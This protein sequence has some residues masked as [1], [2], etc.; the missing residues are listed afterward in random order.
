M[1]KHL[2]GTACCVLAVLFTFA[3]FMGTVSARQND[4][5][6]TSVQQTADYLYGLLEGNVTASDGSSILDL[7]RAGKDASALASE[8]ASTDWS[9]LTFVQK[10]LNAIA[11]KMAGGSAD[12]PAFSAE[13]DLSGENPYNLCTLLRY[14]TDDDAELRQAVIAALKAYY[15]ADSGKGV[16]YWGFSV[17]T[18]GIF[19]GALAAFAGEDEEIAAIVSDAL[20]FIDTLASEAGYGYDEQYFDANADSTAAALTAFAAVGEEEKAQTVFEQL[21]GFASQAEPGAFEYYGAPS[22]YATSD[23]F[24]AMLD[25][26]AYLL[27]LSD[28]TEPVDAEEPTPEPAAETASERVENPETDYYFFTNGTAVYVAAVLAAGVTVF[29]VRSRKKSSCQK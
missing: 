19:V 15:D 4:T 18:N 27:T 10:S 7:I 6:N 16:N 2:K 5:L 29:M 3:F 24:R 25:Y 17:D 20:S 8:L 1:S 11:V 14:L 22:A 21:L 28:E 23:A 9:T 13:I 26:Q 12:R